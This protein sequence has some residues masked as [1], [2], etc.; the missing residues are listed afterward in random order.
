MSAAPRLERWIVTL[1]LVSALAG[2]AGGQLSARLSAEPPAPPGA[3][4]EFR[5]AFEAEFR[6][7]P[8]R[9]RALTSVLDAYQGH[10]EALEARGLAALGPELERLN[11]S[12]SEI[13]RNRVLPEAERERFDQL[14]RARRLGAPAG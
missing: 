13:L 7:G 6:L 5:R 8:D 14:C 4:G 3:F 2:F 11:Q 10:L 1:A 12:L 9:R